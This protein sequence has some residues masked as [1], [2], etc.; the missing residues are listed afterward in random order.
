M[1][2]SAKPP[3]PVFDPGRL[4]GR[5]RLAGAALLWERLWP[6]L[7]PAFGVAG[8]FLAL[9]LFDLPA[10]LPG[11]LHA[12]LLIAVAA[13]LVMALLPVV[14]Q[15]RLP[16]RGAGRR[17]IEQASGLAHRPLTALED[18]MSGSGGDAASVALWQ[19][20][21]ERMAAQARALRVGWPA[22]GWLR[23]DP[24][25]LRAALWLVLLIAAVDAGRDWPQRLER[26]LSPSFS[27]GAPAVPV[28][29]DIWVTPPEYTGLPPQFLPA[30]AP[31]KPIAVPTGSTVLAQVQGGRTP[32]SLKIDDKPTEFTRVDERNFKGSATIADGSRLAVEQDGRTLGAWPIVI[33]PDLPPTIAFAKPPQHS[34]RAVLRLEYLASDD[35]GVENTKA[36]IA[37]PGDPSDPITIDLP[38]PGAHLKEARD[39][40]YHDLTAHPWAGLPVDI[41]LEATDALSQSGQSETLRITLPE[42]V[43]HHPVARAVIEQRKQ[44]TLDPS[45]REM[46]AETLSDLS[47]RPKLFNDDTVAFLA[48]RAA[49]AR[50]LLDKQ[51]KAIPAVQQLLWE[52]AVRIEDGRTS[53]VQR[54]LR[55]AMKALQEALARA[56]PDAEI[57]R[58]MRELQQAID[59]Y[60]QAM[61]Q[62]MERQSPDPNAP[63]MDPSRML[64]QQDL[65]RM[66][67]R[68]RELARTGARDAARNML[69]QLQEMLENLRTARQG[70][71][72]SGQGQAM[73]QM[74][75]MMRRQQQLLDK[76]FRQSRQ[77]QQ[78]QQGQQGRQGQ[79]GQQGQGQRGQRGQG[80][81]G[82][83]SQ[84]DSGDGQDGDMAGDQEALRRQL[85]E[86]MR[87]LGEQPGDI[88][89][90]LG[91][92]ERAMRDA[93]EALQRGQPGSAIGPQTE[94]LDQLQQ[95][96]RNLVEQMLGQMGDGPPDGGEPGDRDGLRQA[97]RDPFGRLNAQDHANGGIDDGGRLRL[98]DP[99][100]NYAVEKAKGILD[101]LRRRA[102][103]R[104]RPELERDYIDRLLKQF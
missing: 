97:E 101:E 4:A 103:E 77:G 24:F 53:L 89:Q 73:R 62:N 37:R 68:A 74:Q 35:Y 104:M 6:A 78:G 75:E 31:E 88:P 2:D 30:T 46:V 41:H 10:Q 98:G 40:S 96:A 34:Q 60:L 26:S 42:R 28:S 76:S 43:F 71:P 91:R 56:A 29:L 83:G 92:A 15:V 44:L 20:H 14:R 1:S 86:M 16:D 65:Q 87:Q 93:A 23:R 33:V 5:L 19:A 100:S 69:S 84:P 66:L 95:A 17:R 64:N 3:P 57:E 82:Q 70:Q 81:M 90:S 52:T 18:R 13:L 63:P 85:G 47:L 67:D 22:A 27:S 25:A 58:L 94:A 50:L 54:D 7:W 59:R 39:A 99:T 79:Q 11:L 51:A 12:A 32:P 8:T 21:R 48:L 45:Q 102:G 55:E 72:R 36:I 61:A 80:Q 9:A 49:Q 38:L